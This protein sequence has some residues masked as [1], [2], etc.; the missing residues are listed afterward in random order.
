MTERRA[1]DE[2]QVLIPTRG[3]S[4]GRHHERP[5][6]APSPGR[7]NPGLTR[8][9]ER[10]NEQI[11]HLGR[12]VV[13]ATAAQPVRVATADNGLR[14]QRAQPVRASWLGGP[15]SVGSGALER[16]SAQLARVGRRMR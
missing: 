11:P 10:R 6:L 4:F 12:T 15:I 14:R 1:F 7:P 2:Q 3:P 8:T 9:L 5:A 16:R 13:E